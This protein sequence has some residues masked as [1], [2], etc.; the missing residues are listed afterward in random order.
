MWIKR[1]V[2]VLLPVLT[3]LIATGTVAQ[4]NLYKQTQNESWCRHIAREYEKHTYVAK[5]NLYDT[6]INAGGVVKRE[7]DREQI[8]EGEKVY[9]KGVTCEPSRVI[10]TLKAPEYRGADKVKIYFHL[11]RWQ[12]EEADWKAIFDQMTDYVF[13][14][15]DEDG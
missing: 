2:S 14:K 11:L 13:E 10:F 9:V 4:T 15:P 12:R 8:P 5:L 3:A 1:S 6:E 7:Y